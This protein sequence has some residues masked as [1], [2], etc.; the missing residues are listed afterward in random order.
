MMAA[1][2]GKA[3]AGSNYLTFAGQ[4]T[5]SIFCPISP[6]LYIYKRIYVFQNLDIPAISTILCCLPV[7]KYEP[8]QVVSQ[9]QEVEEV[10]RSE[11]SINKYQSIM[12]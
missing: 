11:L 3:K 6:F 9:L 7:W 2:Q 8:L 1:I 5:L 10:R 12:I 4:W